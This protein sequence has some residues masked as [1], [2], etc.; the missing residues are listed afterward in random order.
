VQLNEG[1]AETARDGTYAYVERAMSCGAGLPSAHALNASCVRRVCS[2]SGSRR[3]P[4]TTQSHIRLRPNVQHGRAGNHTRRHPVG[5]LAC[6]PYAHTDPQQEHLR[7]Q[8]LLRRASRP[9][10][11]A[12]QDD[13]AQGGRGE[14]GAALPRCTE[15]RAQLHPDHDCH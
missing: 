11:R 15:R 10:M 5:R 12:D 1:P 9:A 8:R 14:R 13:G 7:A 2:T 4:H 3:H 6:V